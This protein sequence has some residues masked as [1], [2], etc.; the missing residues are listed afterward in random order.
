MRMIARFGI[1]FDLVSILLFCFIVNLLLP[2]KTSKILYVPKGG[3]KYI[4]TYLKDEKVSNLNRF[5]EYLLRFIGSPQQGWL[6][7][8]NEEFLKIDFLKKLTIAKAASTKITLIPGETAYIFLQEIAKQRALDFDKLWENYEQKIPFKDGFFIANSYEIPYGLNEEEFIEF[9]Y[10]LSLKEQKK[11]SNELLG[12][13][14]EQEWKKII[15]KASV[16]QKEAANS[17]EMPIISSVIDNRIAKDMKLQ[18]DGTLNYGKYSHVKI[19]AQRLKDDNSSY[20]TYLNAG[21]PIEPVCAVSLE[22][23]KAALN[24]IKSNYLYFYR[25]KKSKKH[26][27]NESYEEHLKAI[28]GN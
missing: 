25:D 15:S 1:V 16:I 6:D 3:Y 26:I 10:K 21:L 28:K 22:A 23:I 14:D 2:V 18:M 24:P 5:D 27:F 13:Y 9:L 17:E 8:G 7:L 20:N 19:T 12:N 4:I 11:I